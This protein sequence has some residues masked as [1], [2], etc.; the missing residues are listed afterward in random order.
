MLEPHASSSARAV[1]A[2]L[3]ALR[4]PLRERL[5]DP[6]GPSEGLG[7]ELGRAHAAGLDALLAGAF[8]AALAGRGSEADPAPSMTLAA[9]GSYGRGAMAL[10]ADV[11]V[12]VLTGSFDGAA[13][14]VEALLYPLW[15]AGLALGHQVVT[16][17]A[18]LAA[19]REDLPSATSLLDWRLLAGDRSLDAELREGASVGPFA[20][21]ELGGFL[22]RLEA[23][24]EQR[25]ERF[26]GS[27]YLLEP[28]VKN[29]PGGLRD[30]DV[31]GWAARARWQV[32]EPRELVRL[33]VFP[34]SAAD[35]VERAAEVVWRIRNLLH[36]H[37]GRRSDRLA[38]D[39][40]EA[41]AERL[42]YAGGATVAVEQL[43]SDYYRAARTITRFRDMV[44]GRARPELGRRRPAVH[45]L[46]D[47][48][49]LFD[50]EVTLA[51]RSLLA[52]RPAIALR[53]VQAAVT[54]HARLHSHIRNAVVEAAGDAAWA[55]ALRASPDAARLFVSLVTSCAECRLKSGTV[56][57]EL[58]DVGLLLAMIPE[59]SP[60]VGRVHHDTYHVY[61]VD[62]HSVAAVD[63]LAA[64]VR[65]DVVVDEGEGDR[66][67]G[68]L[69]CQ[70]AA[71]VTRPHVLF[72]A[73]LLHDVGKAI[74]R[75]DHSE[76]GAE[77]A[78]GVVARLGFD[79]ED[80]DDVALLVRHHLALYHAATRRDLDDPA[81]ASEL[82]ALCREREALRHLY[83]LTV[84]DLSTTS[85]TSMT[86]WKA[87]MLDELF[88][89]ADACFVAGGAGAASLAERR[90]AVAVAAAPDGEEARAF[91]ERFVGAMPARYL[92]GN[93]AEAVAAHVALGWR[94]CRA[95]RPATVGLVPSR[96]PE[97]A[98]I[99]VAAADR[100]GLLAAIAASLAGHRLGVHAAQIY[101][102]DL[103]PTTL[104]IDLFWVHHSEGVPGVARCLPRVE[105]D[106]EQILEGRLEASELARR[107][108]RSGARREGE[109]A[110]PSRVLL[111]NRAAPAHTV[112]EVVTRDRPGLLYALSDALYRLGLTI[113]V[114]KI[115]TEGTRVADVFYVS[116]RDG[117]KLDLERRADGVRD[118][119]LYA[120]ERMAD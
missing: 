21:A 34:R 94:H 57:R 32:A 109:P 55:A 65:G 45:D 73:T 77:V 2:R 29:G 98:E 35:E 46:G 62:A 18:L 106:L 67:L 84:A 70:L 82:A 71:E 113:A 92:L 8:E 33:G 69:A 50:G 110:V 105:R 22:D 48:V 75:R 17:P 74:G 28:D 85:P 116:E 87:R 64:I 93:P 80:A 111:D 41:L 19:A 12:R 31:A 14:A 99:C 53:M 38:F 20:A 13:Q 44:L 107:H 72:F 86:S 103:P 11:D 102:C 47:G 23:A 79:A 24:T 91:A 30:L 4:A 10:G 9:V 7:L 90:R 83:L 1:R 88:V 104:A 39:R 52:E 36:A 81:T 66:W 37:A 108:R 115:A 68:S 26:G 56:M 61:T 49:L 101:S 27:V 54:E 117:T 43:M 76:R 16:I 3:D 15:D 89:S 118:A 114:A 42:G 58:H 119:L 95:A 97:V 25:H 112:V 60:V 63:R 51:E 120:I 96:H 40:Q 100:P 78:R 5:L 59:F 6:E